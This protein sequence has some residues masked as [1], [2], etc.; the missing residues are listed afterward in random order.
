MAKMSLGNVA[1]IGTVALVGL[2]MASQLVFAVDA[3]RF[4]SKDVKNEKELLVEKY[5][6][7]TQYLID[8][9]LDLTYTLAG[10]EERAMNGE[11]PEDLAKSL[12][13]LQTVIREDIKDSIFNGVRSLAGLI[14]RCSPKDVKNC[15]VSSQEHQQVEQIALFINQFRAIYNLPPMDEKAELAQT[16]LKHKKVNVID[17]DGLR[18]LI[19][20]CVI[21]DE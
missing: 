16:K 1:L 15:V 10:M 17:N 20:E 12:P 9:S 7:M 4:I 14:D 2:A 21:P 3:N 8:I 11:L 13:A 5:K 18:R 19:V 6:V